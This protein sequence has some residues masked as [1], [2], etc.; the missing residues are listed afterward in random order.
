MGE[1]L[2]TVMIAMALAV[3]APAATLPS[4]FTETALTT[5]L[6]SAT[7]MALAP[8]G[9]IFVC[10]QG[11]S[12]RVIKNGAR[13][14][15]PFLTVTVNSLGERGLLGV[16]FDPNFPANNF[17]YVY[18]TATIPT[19][20][21]RVSRFTANG[22]VAVSGSETILLELNDL[23]GATNHN[24]GAMHFGPDG[25]L[26]IAVG[27]NANG[28]N[29]QMLTNLL[30]K[31]LRINPDGTIPTDNPFPPPQTTGKN[32]AIWALGLRNPFT[33]AFQSGTGRMFINDVG[34]SAWE[35][36]NNGLA[37]ANYGWPTTEGETTDPR[38]VSPL[39]VYGHGTGTSLGCAITGGAFYNPATVRFPAS[40]VGKYFFAD[41]CSGW[42]RTYDAAT[43][44]AAG[45]ATNAGD[46]V[47]LAIG[48]NGKLYYLNRSSVFEIDA[49]ANQAPQVTTQPQSQTRSAGQSVSFTVAASGTSPLT[50]QWQRNT[51]AI[52]GATSATYTIAS[53]AASDNGAQFRCV[54]TNA[55]GTATSNPATLTVVSNQVPTATITAPAAGALYIAGQTISFA[56]T[57]TDAED[58]QLPSSAFT[59]RI[60]FHH[61]QHTHPAMPATSGITSGTYTIPDSGETSANVFYRIHLTVQDSAGLTF[62]TTRDVLP[63]KATI[64]LDSL[65][66]GAQ[67]LLDGQPVT[68]PFS[69]VGVAGVKR[70]LDAPSPQTI[71]GRQYSFQ[72]WSDDGGQM[73][74]IITPAA[75]TTYRARFKV[76]R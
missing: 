66:S 41:Y 24:G 68:A 1:R 19:I 71:R 20:H 5:S 21:N 50:Y 42:I 25:K 62:E 52:A 73:H 2:I 48:S 67:L 8:D 13:L 57:G 3:A 6:A 26:Y 35:E 34:Q 29:S 51:A 55:F 63:I 23:S 61:D 10:E 15:Q 76:G 70:T 39:F 36:I 33:F 59:W 32:A 18:Y 64:K 65:P 4:G 40:Y 37:G 58:G 45:F 72:S 12:L 53:V 16:A 43:D 17:V 47:D 46:V 74:V 30:G 69:F 49:T 14:P 54:V 9:R 38:F 7:A 56:G 22:D 27:E 75:N 44:A 28:A 31:I 60:D 11:G